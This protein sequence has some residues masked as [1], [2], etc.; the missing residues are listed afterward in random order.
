[1]RK[2]MAKSRHPGLLRSAAVALATLLEF[3]AC[4][5]ARGY[6]F[7]MIVPDIRQP[8]SASGGSACPVPSRQASGAGNI[9]LRWSTALG[10]SPVTIL[11]QSTT[12]TA[13][14]N[15][16]EQTIS[17]ALSVWTGVAG[18]SLTP[19]ALSPLTRISSASACSSSDGIDSICFDQPDAGFTPGVLAFTRVVSA[20]RVGEQLGA[21]APSTFPGQIL[22]ADLYFNPSDSNATFATPAALAAN[23]KAYDLESILTHELG[24]FFGFSHS[25]V[26]GAM[27]FPY[28]HMTGTFASPRP[29]AQAPDGP[30]GDDDRAGLRILYPAATDDTYI[31]SIS[32]RV[33]P[34]N[35]LSLPASPPNVTGIFGAQVVA[36][37]AATGTVAAATIA[38]WSCAAAGPARFDG[39]YTLA[40]LAVGHSYSVY[41]EP[42]DGAVNPSQMWNAIGTLCRNATTDGNWP[43]AYAC[44]VPSPDTQFTVGFRS[45]P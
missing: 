30:L 1:M 10:G 14:T 18:T 20:D 8:A 6:A 33:L 37:D 16:I 35:P 17:T 31:G 26:W 13:Q 2:N 25:A 34:A 38:G 42:L 15:E 7:A 12:A 9:A 4:A 40:K 36:L 39:A 28:A 21:G 23:P 41:A 29:T 19:S 22:D 3:S 44:V 5:S 24:H 45:S 11:T 43:S 27:M 32:G